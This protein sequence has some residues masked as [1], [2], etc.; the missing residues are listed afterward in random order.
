MKLSRCLRVVFVGGMLAGSAFASGG[1]DFQAL[2]AEAAKGDIAAQLALAGA[3]MFGDGVA[4]D[5]SEAL[6]WYRLAADQGSADAQMSLGMVYVGGQGVP[7]DEKEAVKWF[8]LAGEQG[9]VERRRCSPGSTP[10]AK[11][12]RRTRR[13][14]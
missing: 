7:Q 3:C 6:K 9:L 10:P 13:R 2:R 14:R 5:E 11:A 8:R 1:R 12:C 4:R